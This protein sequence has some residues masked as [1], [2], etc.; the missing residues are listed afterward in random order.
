MNPAFARYFV[1]ATFLLVYCFLALSKKFRATALWIGVAA[2]FFV[3]RALT[4]QEIIAAINWNVI[5]IFAG[6]LILAEMFVRSK[7]P[8]L[9]ANGLV[10]RSGTVGTAILLVCVLSSV[11]SAFAENVAKAEMARIVKVRRNKDTRD[12]E[13]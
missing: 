10:R 12:S 8:V 6:T 3:A 13:L 2:I 5:G 9:L 4:L 1:L 7:M 11:I